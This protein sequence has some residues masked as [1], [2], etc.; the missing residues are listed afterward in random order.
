MCYPSKA[1]AS[2]LTHCAN[3]A[4][5][6]STASPRNRLP[7][8]ASLVSCAKPE[9]IGGNV[10][11]PFLRDHTVDRHSLPVM[12]VEAAAASYLEMSSSFKHGN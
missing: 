10:E 12:W 3:S 8:A 2:R 1:G 7:D 9:S 5:F 6:S 4:R 11:S